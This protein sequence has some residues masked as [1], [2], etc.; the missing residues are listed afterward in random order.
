MSLGAA[1]KHLFD[2]IA[3]QVEDYSLVVWY[4]PEKHYPGVAESLQLPKTTVARYD[5]SF[6]KLRR[7]IDHLLNEL[8]PPRLIV[9]VPVD[10]SET[11]HALIELEA[12]GVVMQ[13]GQQPPQRNTRLAIIARNALKNVLGEDIAADVEKQV[14]AGKLSLADLN[15]LAEKGSEISKG[16]LSLIFGTGN[17]QEIA[18]AFLNSDN[19]AGEIEKKSA[20]QELSTLFRVAFDTELPAKTTLGE[21]REKLARHVLLTELSHKLD[22]STPSSLKAVKIAAAPG[23]IEACVRLANTWRQVRDCR[24]SYISAAT[25]SSKISR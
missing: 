4:D 17:S 15:A 24:D 25:R 6:I 21:I 5:G 9:Y 1:T 12:A 10:Q 7:Q 16:V 23:G 18:L 2:L 19:F 3:K 14:E 22:K 11:H 8:E 20:A 13:P